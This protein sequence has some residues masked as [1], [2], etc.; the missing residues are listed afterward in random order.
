MELPPEPP[1]RPWDPPPA[2]EPRRVV[3]L[4]YGRNGWFA[5][6]PFPARVLIGFVGY[7]VFCTLLI[8]VG[9]LIK[10]RADDLWAI[11]LVVTTLMFVAAIYARVRYR[12]SGVGYGI[13]LSMLL[14]LVLAV[15]GVAIL[16]VGICSGRVPFR[17][18]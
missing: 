8:A 3:P 1:H 16:I 4:E 13:L 14:A 10:L 15:F 2:E 11:W 6:L 12:F 17:V 7:T 18:N 5:R 9:H